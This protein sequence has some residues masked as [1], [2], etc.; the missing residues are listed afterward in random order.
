MLLPF[1]C[2]FTPF[3][4]CCAEVTAFTSRVTTFD[5]DLTPVVEEKETP[6]S[7]DEVYDHAPV[8]V[9]VEICRRNRRRGDYTTG[10]G[11]S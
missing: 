10:C 1:C 2:V 7:V 4:T 9:V 6:D 11:H 5:D 8:V 3:E